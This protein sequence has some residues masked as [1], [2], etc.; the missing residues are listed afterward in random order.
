M[1]KANSQKE[2]LERSTSA[3]AHSKT[4]PLETTIIFD[5]KYMTCAKLP[6]PPQYDMYLGISIFFSSLLKIF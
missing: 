3:L 1:Q 4:T 5:K 6:S 2:N